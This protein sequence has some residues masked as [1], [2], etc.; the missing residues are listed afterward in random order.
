MF[1]WLQIRSKADT[2]LC[3]DTQFKK[4]NER[5]NLEPCVKDGSGRSGEQ[6]TEGLCYSKEDC[7]YFFFLN[8]IYFTAICVDVAQRYSTA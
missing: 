8:E 5:F 7:C 1:Q 2:A 4:E 3:I 6:V